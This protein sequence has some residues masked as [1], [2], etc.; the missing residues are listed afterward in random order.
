MVVEGSMGVLFARQN[1][2]N[3][4]LIFFFFLFFLLPQIT[5]NNI[6]HYLK[7]LCTWNLDHRFRLGDELNLVIIIVFVIIIIY[8]DHTHNF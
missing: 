5:W 4:L 7:R 2:E 3:G 8:V 1:K 6:H